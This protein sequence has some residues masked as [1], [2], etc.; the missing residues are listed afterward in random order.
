MFSRYVDNFDFS[1][2]FRILKG[3][4]ISL[5]VSA[6]LGSVIISHAAPIGGVVTSGNA[7][8]AQS[9][10]TT[11]ITQSTQ[12]ASINWQGFSI[13]SNETVNFKQPN[14]NS[15][16]LNRVVGNE[17]SVIDGA[18]NAN[19]Q[20]WI[21][22]SNGILFNSTAKINTA[23]ILATTKDISDADFQAGNYKFSGDSTAS[24]VNMGTI[25][26]SDNGYVALLA[27]KVSNDGT[28]KAYKGTVHL[29][30]ASEATINLNGNS[31]VSLT[32]NKGVLDALVENKGAV[33]ADGGKIYLTTN[34]VDELLKGVVNNTGIIEANSVDDISGEIILF[35]H[36]G[37]ANVGGKL[38]ASAP[39]GGDGGFIETSGKTVNIQADSFVS[40][41]SST[42][43]TG[44]WLIDPNDFVVAATNGNMTGTQLQTAL[45][46]NN[47]I[48]ET[49]TMGD[50]GG[51]GQGDIFINDAVSWSAN[52]LTLKAQ[53]HINVNAVMSMSG[54]AS[55]DMGYGWNG[56][57][58]GNAVSG[59]ASGINMGFNSTYTGYAGKI[60]I[61]AP[62]TNAVTINGNSYT[63]ISD[64]AGLNNLAAN[65]R[66]VVA[67]DIDVSSIA[68]WTGKSLTYTSFDLNGFGHVISG[69]TSTTNGLINSLVKGTGTVTASIENIGL[70]SLNVNSTNT[71]AGSIGGLIGSAENVTIK[72]SFVSG[73]VRGSY[74]RVSGLVG[75]LY[76]HTV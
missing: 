69:L 41:K 71:S 20:V 6:I 66:Y 75:L 35:A 68:D 28:I 19:G 32:V 31:I 51:V 22:N 70:D 55:I 54:T 11:N 49:T 27:N 3:G 61:T 12:K 74:D 13:N 7:T 4:K 62:S 63:I 58:Y 30:G 52:K 40:T 34:A 14:V 65:K 67:S 25:E 9:G 18:L 53:R 23:G 64:V 17:R 47:F 16:T 56:T 45:A 46:S 42:G 50:D 36:G 73:S 57:T 10:N 39:N 24:V 59:V 21:L 26:A 1:S 44:T 15:I 38:D 29:T 37:T 2:R 33:I 60:N 43:K 8:I 5:V 48:I 72:N 76:A